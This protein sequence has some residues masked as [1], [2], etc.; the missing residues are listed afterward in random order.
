MQFYE[1]NVCRV[2]IFMHYTVYKK[3]DDDK[4]ADQTREK[5][6]SIFASPGIILLPTVSGD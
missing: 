2:V 1:I 6:A 4:N 3:H 5:I